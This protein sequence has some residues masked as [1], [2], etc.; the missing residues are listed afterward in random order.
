L[1]AVA[2]K[3]KII[4]SIPNKP[5]MYLPFCLHLLRHLQYG[6]VLLRW[7]VSSR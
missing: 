2:Y 6:I 3:K 1:T 7:L 5:T 4:Q